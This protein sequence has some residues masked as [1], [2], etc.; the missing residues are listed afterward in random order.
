[1]LS[2]FGVDGCHLHFAGLQVL[3]VGDSGVGK[4]S[5]LLRFTTDEFAESTSPTIG[6]LT[7]HITFGHHFDREV[8]GYKTRTDTCRGRL[9]AEVYN[10]TRPSYK[11]YYL[12]HSGS[13]TIPNID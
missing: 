1:M 12:G 7:T 13:R 10:F 3:L 2:A 4:S 8:L 11:A 5:L 9:S 6:T